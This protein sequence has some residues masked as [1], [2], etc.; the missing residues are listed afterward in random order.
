MTFFTAN[1]N[2]SLKQTSPAVRL[3]TLAKSID[4]QKPR[5]NLQFE[6]ITRQRNDREHLFSDIIKQIETQNCSEITL[7]EWVYCLAS[8][9]YWNQ[10][11]YS[12]TKSL[13]TKIWRFASNYQPLKKR[14]FWHLVVFHLEKQ[15]KLIS[16]LTD[17]LEIYQP[18]NKQDYISLK[19]INLI[20]QDNYLDLALL[21]LE[22]CVQPDRL[23]RQNCLPNYFKSQTKINLVKEI[24]NHFTKALSKI[25]HLQSPQINFLIDI[26]E[27]L[28]PKNQLVAVETLLLQIQPSVAGNYP[29]LVDWVKQNYLLSTQNQLSTKGKQLF[30]KWLGAINYRNFAQLVDLLI[31]RV[32]IDSVEDKQ[33]TQRKIF[34]SNY[35]DRFTRI[36]ILLPFSTIQRLNN[37][38]NSESITQLINDGSQ[39]TEVVIIDFGDYLI[40]EF[41]RGKGGEVRVFTKTKELEQ[42]LFDSE[43][44]YLKKIRALSIEHTSIFDR[45]VYWQT[46][47]AQL[48]ETQEIFPNDYLDYLQIEANQK[49]ILYQPYNLPSLN[50]Q[51]QNQRQKQLSN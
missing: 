51:Q 1:L 36:R 12:Q 46:E 42:E 17:T 19:I 38:F 11:D 31:E 9:N 16:G 21:C 7:V 47:F 34:W 20:I 26:V 33:L 22:G 24:Q 35:S 29:K 32:S 10:L 40:V 8:Q 27:N 14:L 37:D 28:S 25:D 44:M 48:L 41:F 4:Q 39:S 13:C 50:L 49:G 15:Q 18:Q 23:L 6:Q 5:S 30:K 45:C 43:D 2:L 3:I